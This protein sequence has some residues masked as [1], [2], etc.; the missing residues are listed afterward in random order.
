MEFLKEYDA[1]EAAKTSQTK[2]EHLL[3]G[4]PRF[5]RMLYRQYRL[6]MRK[7]DAK[8]LDERLKE[9]AIAYQKECCAK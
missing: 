9:I 5:G 1:D 6:K 2:G 8:R 3:I 7:E 4:Q